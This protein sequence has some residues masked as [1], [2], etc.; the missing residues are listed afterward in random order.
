MRFLA[1]S[2]F[3]LG[4]GAD[5]GAA[6]G[7]RLRDQALAL[8]QLS[9]AAEQHNVDGVLFAGDAFQHRRPSVDELLTFRHWLSGLADRRIP[10]WAIPGNH[11]VRGPGRPSALSL[12]T[13]R[14]A[15][16]ERGETVRL[17]GKA[18][19]AFLPWAHPST[20]RLGPSGRGGE[21]ILENA[22]A[23]VEVAAALKGELDAEEPSVLVAHWAISG[24]SL[25]SGLPAS[26]LREPV[27]PFHD[28]VAQ[29]WDCIVAGHIHRGQVLG[30]KVLVPG[31]PAVCDFGEEGQRHGAWIVK[32]GG[33]DPD[34]SFVPLK[35]RPF[36]T[37]EKRYR[38]GLGLDLDQSVAEAV[39]RLRLRLEEGDEPDLG[40]IRKSLYDWGAHKV[41]SIEVER[42]R[43]VRASAEGLREDEGLLDLF[44]RWLEARD[45]GSGEAGEL[46]ELLKSYIEEET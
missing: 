39:V 15:L 10:V 34:F 21:A 26:A 1:C 13:D 7:S 18:G 46:R 41:W 29:G 5:Y 6:P 40:V 38:D 8:E 45:F 17:A 19:L 28:L 3:Q 33:E 43:S 16:H 32:V 25:P 23:L 12:F 31:S 20:W 22:D 11:D 35:D 42:P 24:A 30:G 4:A 37:L 44:D 2:D 27:L 9:A 36:V 14:L